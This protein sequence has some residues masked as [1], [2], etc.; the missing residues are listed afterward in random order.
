L[1]FNGPDGFY[2]YRVASVSGS[3]AYPIAANIP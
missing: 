3:G 2:R 1:T